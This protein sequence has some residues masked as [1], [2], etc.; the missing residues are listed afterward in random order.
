MSIE[1]HEF[2]DKRTSRSNDQ[3]TWVYKG[4]VIYTIAR[5]FFKPLIEYMD[6]LGSRELARPLANIFGA[7]YRR[8]KEFRLIFEVDRF[9][10]LYRPVANQFETGRGR[11][12]FDKGTRLLAVYDPRTPSFIDVEL[13]EDWESEKSWCF[14]LTPEEWLSIITELEEIKFKRRSK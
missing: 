2:N 7:P 5:K 9:P 12:W 14:R 6:A 1:D 10:G 13:F 11:R 4:D 8:T 3:H